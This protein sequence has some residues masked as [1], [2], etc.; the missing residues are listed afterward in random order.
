MSIVFIGVFSENPY[1]LSV[2]ALIALFGMML[3]MH[4][5]DYVYNH[6]IAKLVGAH[7][8]PGRGSELQI[9][10][11]VALIFTLCVITLI[12]FRSPI[13]YSLLAILYIL[14]SIFFLCIFLFRTDSRK[15]SGGGWLRGGGQE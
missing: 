7:Q 10:S 1:I 11:T 13:N 5:F 3:P 2:A 12:L 15:S 4:P 9:N 8:I 14:S 6:G